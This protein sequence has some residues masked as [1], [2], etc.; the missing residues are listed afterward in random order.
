[1]ALFKMPRR[2]S[3]HPTGEEILA[4]EIFED[5]RLRESGIDPNG[6]P[7][8]IMKQVRLRHEAWEVEERLRAAEG[9]IFTTPWSSP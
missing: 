2:R 3:D 4:M 7:L 5:K 6:D 8:D 9:L 1:M